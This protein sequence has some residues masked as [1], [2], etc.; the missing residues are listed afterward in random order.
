MRLQRRRVN[1]TQVVKWIQFADRRR[2]A[3]CLVGSPVLGRC[4]GRR[5]R[6]IAHGWRLKMCKGMEEH[7]AWHRRRHCHAMSCRVEA[8][9]GCTMRLAKTELA[10]YII[11]YLIS[12]FSVLL[13]GA[14]FFIFFYFFLLRYRFTTGTQT[15]IC[16]Y[17]KNWSL[18]AE[19][20]STWL[21]RTN[22]QV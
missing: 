13:H 11:G 10:D 19:V 7:G 12:R 14:F 17:E 22:C 16:C 1:A 6:C 3:T 5:R 9:Y 8:W 18:S 21:C 4:A 2:R 15:G 20:G